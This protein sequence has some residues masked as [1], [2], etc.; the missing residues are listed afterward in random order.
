MAPRFG[1]KRSGA[2]FAVL[3]GVFDA[4]PEEEEEEEEDWA[5]TFADKAFRC[6]RD[7]L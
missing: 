4:T 5:S 6:H 1:M 3:R 2:A 7:Y